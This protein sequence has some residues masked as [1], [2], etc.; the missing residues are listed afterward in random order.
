M[1]IQRSTIPVAL[2]V[3]VSLCRAPPPPQKQA[4][5]SVTF[6]EK[7]KTFVIVD[8][9]DK[10]A[11]A[12]ATFTDDIQNSGWAHLNLTTNPKYDDSVQAYAA[13]L[14][15][16]YL[17]STLIYYHWVNTV[18]E[19]CV[20]PSEY[21]TKL[22]KY[23][24]ANLQWMTQQ[25]KENP[26]D[27]YWHQVNLTL[28][29]LMG[30]EDGFHNSIKEPRIDVEPFGFLL[31]QIDGD[32]EDLESALTNGKLKR[33]LG[34]GSCSALIKLLPGNSDLYVSHVTWS[35]YQSMLRV[36]KKYDFG[37]HQSDGSLMPGRTSSFSSNPGRVFS[38]DDFYIIESGLVTL[39]TT[40]GNSNPA[41][42]KYVQPEGQL[43]EWLRNIIANRLAKDAMM[44][45]DIFRKYNSGTYNN[46]WMVVD[47]NRFVPHQTPKTGLLVI[48][49]Q[50]PGLVVAED[51]TDV[52][53]GQSYWPSYN[54]PY[55]KEIFNAS[56]LPAK[57]AKYGDW[58]TYE[59]TPRA[60]MF[61]RNQSQVTDMKSMI[62]LMRYNDFQH[63]ELSKCNCTPP[64]SGENAISAR[65][66]LN[67]ANGTYPFSTL[68]NRSHGGTDMKV[69]NMAMHKDFSMIAICGPTHDQQPVFQ[70]STSGFNNQ[71]HLGQP[72]RFDFEQVLV[73][74][75]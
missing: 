11:T 40:N 32:L 59:K 73:K 12:F 49:E 55:F 57:V 71:S 61:L 52:L 75:N 63:D 2:L 9:Y 48:L 5:A 44:W 67:P 24:Q 3:L 27:D 65:S 54:V 35:P 62:K 14:I 20:Q 17:S 28:I 19:F 8:V 74:W 66:D 47:Y 68:G 18:Y 10:S 34:S 29:Q 22:K 58:F 38:G 33:P 43:L 6:D 42:W 31:L 30:I 13:G 72:D 60:L 56:G 70:W 1:A 36:M 23:L 53:T 41:L 4:V 21:C 64:Y 50:L 45:A 37:Y 69:T 15:E 25:I 46:Q 51:K 39:E 26:N 7:T 16:G